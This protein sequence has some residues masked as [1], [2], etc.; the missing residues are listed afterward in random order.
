MKY[1]RE[2]IDF[3]LKSLKREK[4]NKKN[5]S[6]TR[7]RRGIFFYTPTASTIRPKELE[8]WLPAS[9]GST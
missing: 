3:T 5:P 9:F 2:S 7:R 4:S 6:V 8:F 1:I